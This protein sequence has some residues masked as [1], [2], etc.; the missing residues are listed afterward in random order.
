MNERKDSNSIYY[1]S[2]RIP[3]YGTFRRKDHMTIN[4]QRYV[5]MIAVIHNSCQGWTMLRIFWEALILT[6]KRV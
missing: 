3:L 4:K 1:H 6:I 2:K 5:L